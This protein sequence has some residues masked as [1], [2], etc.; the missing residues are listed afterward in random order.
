MMPRAETGPLE[1]HELTAGGLAD[2]IKRRELS[3]V[4]AL[5][6]ALR[7]IEAHNPALNAVVSLDEDRARRAA[8]RADAELT[9]E[10]Q[11]GP[12]HGVPLTLKDGHDV[13]GLRTTVGTQAFD[14]V[15]DEDGSVAARLRLAGAV[16]IGH[17][18]VPAFL[19]DY[20]SDN[21]IFGRTVNPW[22]P[23]RTAGGSSGGAAAA[24]AAG[25]TPLDVGSDLTGSL[26]LPASF[27][28]VYGLKTTEHRVPMTG[29]FRQPPGTPRSV[30]ILSCLGPIARDLDDLALALELIAGPDG[31]N[32]DVPPVAVELP[33]TPSIAGLR[34]AVAETLPGATTGAAMRVVV[35]GLASRLSDA[36]AH[37]EQRL[38]EIDWGSSNELFMRVVGAVTGIFAPGSELDEEQRSLAWY[39]EAL[40]RRDRLVAAWEAFFEQ[41]DVLVLPSAMA[42]AFSHA[43]P[44]AAV[45]VDGRQISYLEHGLLLVFANMAGLPAL[46]A[47]AGLDPDGLPVGV[48]LVGKRWSEER[49]IALARVME[50]TGVLPGFRGPDRP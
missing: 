44:Y 8:Q 35:T 33:P 46:T 39:L 7:R 23:D 9:R 41:V 19:A 26:R 11:L 30:R 1:V 32:A 31:Q 43:E 42:P 50:E 36:G 16:I 27:C 6:G 20:Q 17:T 48:Q 12:L 25:L 47:P 22:S 5:D 40:D 49:L 45:D 3:A 38:P 37:V 28:G 2:L 13:A 14:R 18:N 15:A 10:S 21:A 24:V 29:F 34:V 4:E